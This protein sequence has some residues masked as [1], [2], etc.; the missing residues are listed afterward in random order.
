VSL[1][2]SGVSQ[3][4]VA[5]SA[6]QVIVETRD[7]LERAV[8]GLNLCPFAAGAYSGNRVRYCVSTHE[9]TTGLLEELS[10]ELQALKAANPIERE[11]TLLIHPRVLNDFY[12]YNE[13][14]DDCDAALTA[15]GLDGE[16]QIASFHPNYRFANSDAQDMQNYSNRSPYP[17]LH[18]LREA[19]ITRAVDSYPDIDH[20]VTNNMHT[21]R[22]LG[23]AG[24]QRL[25]T[26]KS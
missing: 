17:M 16:L 4:P 25:W 23:I 6:E 9:S 2:D 8:I 22:T 13:F 12:R 15:L 7:W 5:I 14:L 10:H 21:L 11:T 3:V 1:W 24:W 19:S 26:N 18:L 20:V